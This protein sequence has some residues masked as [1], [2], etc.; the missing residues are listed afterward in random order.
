MEVDLFNLKKDVIGKINLSDEIFDVDVRLDLVSQVVHWQRLKKM[1]GNHSTKNVGQVS[2]SGKKPFKQKGTGRAR[3]GNIRAVQRRHGGVSHGPVVRSHAISL[4]KKVRILGLK[5]ALT[6]KR[7]SNALYVVDQ[8]LLDEIKTSVLKNMLLNFSVSSIFLIDG[9]FV[10]E[11][12]KLSIRNTESHVV[13]VVGANVYDI[14]NNSCV[15][16]SRD[17]VDCLERRLLK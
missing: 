7:R 8:F 16:I 5:S 1:S 4:N 9:D 3:C 17:A 10:Q 15:L 2:G 11:N 13:P 14:V 12:F 6:D